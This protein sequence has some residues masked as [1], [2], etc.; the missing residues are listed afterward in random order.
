MRRGAGRLVVL[1]VLALQGCSWLTIK[2]EYGN[3][4]GGFYDYGNKY[5]WQL[6]TCQAEI[7]ARAVADPFR[8]RYMEC[9][10]W[11]HGVPI[12]DSTGCQA[13]PYYSG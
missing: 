11:R 10:M 12:T 4:Y 2:D 5:E 7:S 13:P 3:R 1:G 8:K 6:V 9:C